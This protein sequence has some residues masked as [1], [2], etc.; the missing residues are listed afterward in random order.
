MKRFVLVIGLSLLPTLA[1]AQQINVPPDK[2]FELQIKAIDIEKISKA[3]SELPYK[4]VADLMA[5]MRQQI[6]T[7]ATQKP[8]EKVIPPEPEK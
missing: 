5:S 2:V 4:D 3:L 1:L 7:Q 8:V 6:F